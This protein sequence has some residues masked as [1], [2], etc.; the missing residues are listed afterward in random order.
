M[1]NNFFYERKDRLTQEW[2]S[3]VLR[4]GTSVDRV[5]ALA[6]IVKENPLSS[7]QHIESLLAFVSPVKKQLC[8]KAI[9]VLSNL[10]ENFLLP[11][12][13]AL[14]ALEDRPFKVLTKHPAVL[15]EEMTLKD[16]QHGLRLPHNCRENILALWYFEHMLKHCY[17]RFLTALE[18]IFTVILLIWYV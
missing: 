10:F 9:D 17:S 11:S 7:L 14:I 2:L 18:V 15:K 1:A 13:R 5:L 12:K 6:F 3:T 4:R 8:M 16:A